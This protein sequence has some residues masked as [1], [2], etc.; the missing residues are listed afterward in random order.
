MKINPK[1]EKIPQSNLDSLKV[2]AEAWSIDKDARLNFWSLAM[3][4]SLVYIWELLFLGHWGLVTIYTYKIYIIYM[5]KVEKE[6]DQNTWIPI[7]VFK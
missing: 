3:T 5:F 6:L 7:Q 2:L 1:I 4:L